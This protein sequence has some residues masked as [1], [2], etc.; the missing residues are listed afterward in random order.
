M[1][2]LGQTSMIEHEALV[3]MAASKDF[4][5]IILVGHHF[6]NINVGEPFMKVANVELLKEMLRSN[7]I[8]GASILIKGSRTNKLE[9]LVEV[10]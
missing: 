9:Q 7:Q 5:K 2:E 10:L 8:S 6:E 1:N 4:S 3:A